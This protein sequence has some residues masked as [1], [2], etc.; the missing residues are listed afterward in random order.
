MANQFPYT[1]KEKKM[2]K[3]IL[4]SLIAATCLFSANLMAANVTVQVHNEKNQIINLDVKQMPERVIALNF[5]SVDILDKL[6]L[7]DRI[8]GMVKGNMVPEHLKKYADNPN[9]ANVG[10]MK[11]VDMEKLMSLQPDLIL[12]SDRTIKN[13]KKFSVVAPTVA[14]YVNYKQGFLQGFKHNL[15]V[16]AKIFNK[17]AE[18]AKIYADIESRVTSLQQKA[19]DKTAILG[20][21]TGGSLK[22]LGDKGRMALITN[23]IGFKNL[24]EGVNINHGNNSSYELLVQKDPDFLF[25]LDKDV[26][27]GA[28]AKS[29]KQ[30][31]DNAL[32]KQMKAH[33]QNRIAFLEPG[34]AWYLA[35]GGLTSMDLMLANIETAL[36]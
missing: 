26:A 31:L 8:V 24:A 33:Q 30:L 27:V 6:G 32:I 29:A 11:T 1:V 22:V 34:S 28:N 25:I 36:N 23:D 35:D 4:A 16:H 21:F 9:I 10:G 20:L 5:T 3:Q 13:Y 19:K 18:A 15:D 12:S 2:K 14:S 17:E 7:G